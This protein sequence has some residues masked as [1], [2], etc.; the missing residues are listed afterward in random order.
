[1]GLFFKSKEENRLDILIEKIKMNM[2]NNY[3]D[4][5][6]KSLADF[7]SQ[8]E[9]Y[10]TTGALKSKVIPYYEEQLQV[11]SE[12]LVGYGH[13]EQKPFWTKEDAQNK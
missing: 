11:F 7:Q 9:A 8:L 12:K 6:H 3:K 2:Q 5:A 1:M 4:A 10:K 13:L